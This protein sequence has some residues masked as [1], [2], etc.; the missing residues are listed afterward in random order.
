MER[1]ICVSIDKINL[2]FA[3]E[4]DRRLIYELALED[5]EVALSMFN[6][7]TDFHWEELRDEKNFYFDEQ[8]GRSKYLLIEYDKEIIGV[9][10]HVH[11]AALIENIE[12]HIW[13]RSLKY[14]GRGIGT[15]VLNTMLKYLKDKYDINTFLMR[16]WTKNIRA[17]ATYKKCG[18]EVV[19]NF[20]LTSYFTKEEVA[21]Y[22][23]GAYSEEETVNMVHTTKE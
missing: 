20:P 16:P 1:N 12:F 18:F 21:L 6:K 14:T 13:M 9:F 11:H 17:V 22:G 5:K 15:Q 10:C 3:N 2:L 23:N 7:S 19:E 4:S 8:P